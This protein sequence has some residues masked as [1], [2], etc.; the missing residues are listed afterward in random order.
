MV[1]LHG[2][3]RQLAVLPVGV[4][5]LF[6]GLEPQFVIRKGIPKCIQ[7]V[8]CGRPV[9]ESNQRRA[10][11]VLG[12]WTDR[13]RRRCGANPQKMIGC[14]AVVARLSCELTLLVDRGGEV[15]DQCGVRFVILGCDRQH[16]RECLLGLRVLS[17]FE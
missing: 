14:R 4:G 11:I 10:C 12:C 13:G 7:H 9:F 2:R 15:V 16:L 17:E 3:V 1:I 5:D 6:V 8:H